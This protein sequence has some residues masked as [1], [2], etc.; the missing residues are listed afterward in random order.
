MNRKVCAALTILMLGLLSCIGTEGVGSGTAD[1]DNGADDDFDDDSSDCANPNNI[2]MDELYTMADF[3]L[4]D[5]NNNPQNLYSLCWH[6]V[7]V[8]S[9]VGWCPYCTNEAK[10]IAADIYEPYHEQGLEIFFTLFE[11]DQHN[12]PSQAYLQWYKSNYQLPFHV[13]SDPT[14]FL[15]PYQDTY[16]DTTVPFNILLDKHMVIRLEKVGYSPK[17]LKSYIEALLN[18]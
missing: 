13:Y 16:P 5:E 18:E 10:H 2:G 7:L 17:T 11:D 3:A 6:V 9:A 8:V 15:C 4:Y 1:D 12:P 14:C